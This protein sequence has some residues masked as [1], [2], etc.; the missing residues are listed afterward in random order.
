MIYLIVFYYHMWQNKEQDFYCSTEL[1]C[2]MDSKIFDNGFLSLFFPPHFYCSLCRH[3]ISANCH[4]ILTCCIMC[5]FKF[6]SIF[7]NNFCSIFV[8]KFFLLFLYTYLSSI[9]CS[10]FLYTNISFYLNIDV[11]LFC[12]WKDHK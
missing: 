12:K 5:I 1:E 4:V 7:V 8:N 6:S 2:M 10:F 3:S 9:F 11:F